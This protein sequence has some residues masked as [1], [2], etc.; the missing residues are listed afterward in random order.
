MSDPDDG[1]PDSVTRRAPFA[2]N[3]S[4]GARGQQARQK[5]LD[6]AVQVFGELGYHGCRIS[7]ITELTGLSRVSFYQ[8]FSS[9]EDLFRQLAGTVA[10]EITESIDQLEP[11]GADAAGW[12]V[13]HG[14]MDR[15]SAIYDQ[16]E[17]VFV[18]FQSA[19]ETDT[20]IWRGA[21]RV[22]ER[23]NSGLQAKVVGSPLTKNQVAAVVA[24]IFETVMRGNRRSAI[25]EAEWP[26][27]MGHRR[28]G[29]NIA[30]ADVFHRI[31]FGVDAEVNV[32][33]QQHPR[34]PKRRAKPAEVRLE[35][36]S[37]SPAAGRTRDL[38]IETSHAVFA[39]RGFHRTRVDDIVTAAG[40]SHGIFYRYFDS[41]RDVFG[42]LAT[43]AGARMAAGLA[44]LE[45]LEAP[46]PGTDQH[47][48][49]FTEWLE[50]YAQ[51]YAEE[52]PIIATWVDSMSR[53]GKL[54]ELSRD[55][56]DTG[57]QAIVAFLGARGFGD[58]RSEAVAMMELLD[59]FCS[60]PAT[61]R[62]V[63]FF[64]WLIERGLLTAP[65]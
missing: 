51:R 24:T 54:D 46:L 34:R 5:I 22:G 15:F 41:K 59:A 2:A 49:E 53:S 50:R 16:Y 27:T 12:E 61:A 65:S 20:E 35:D 4:V 28:A 10:A 37:L 57:H 38:L 8:Y 14:W 25:A 55:A 6:A 36:P 29:L 56:V 45:E 44:E 39:E 9:K 13:L 58:D 30:L 3:P 26:E 31:L 11:F 19:A 32:H 42:L 7:R 62:R 47:D 60:Q 23:A 17:S 63:S 18:A 48:A 33:V 21:T 1:D 52:G 43:R 40:V 64:R